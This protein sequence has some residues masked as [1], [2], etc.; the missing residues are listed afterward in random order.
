MWLCDCC[1][2][3]LWI[4][5]VSAVG[6]DPR[7]TTQPHLLVGRLCRGAGGCCP[8]L[9]DVGEGRCPPYAKPHSTTE[10]LRSR[11]GQMSPSQGA[12]AS[13]RPHRR[14]RQGLKLRACASC[15]FSSFLWSAVQ[16][17]RPTQQ[18]TRWTAP[19]GLRARGLLHPHPSLTWLPPLCLLASPSSPQP[20]MFPSPSPGLTLL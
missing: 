15:H 11:P 20:P 19:Q 5:I 8:I 4:T 7:L 13:S 1:T 6:P 12:A 16:I 2:R 18:L 3:V 9:L 17:P 10:A 14:W